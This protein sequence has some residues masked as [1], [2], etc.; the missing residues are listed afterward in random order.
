MSILRSRTLRTLRSPVLSLLL[1]AL[2]V[3]LT[4]SAAHAQLLKILTEA[5]A[6]DPV[7]G[8]FLEVVP[9]APVVTPGPGG[10]YDGFLQV[11][12]QASARGQL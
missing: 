10:D 5:D 3:M 6:S 4:T 1:A 8:E 11:E 7:T 12:S 2:T 9:G